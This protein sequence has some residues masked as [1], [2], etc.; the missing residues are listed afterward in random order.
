MLGTQKVHDIGEIVGRFQVVEDVLRCGGV[1]CEVRNI[2]LYSC[3][4]SVLC[5]NNVSPH[6]DY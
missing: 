3:E 6:S 5:I 1:V 4:G 2:E